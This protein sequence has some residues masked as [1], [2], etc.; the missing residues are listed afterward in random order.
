MIQETI[1]CQHHLL[2]NFIWK[3][4]DR[5]LNQMV[6]Y[7]TS[8]FIHLTEWTFGA[9]HGSG[10]FMDREAKKVPPLPKICHT[11]PSVIK[12]GTVTP[13]LKEL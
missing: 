2:E 5:F 10:L 8:K 4:L 11:Y 1:N 9:I 13:Y 12:F 7:K 3:G 6:F